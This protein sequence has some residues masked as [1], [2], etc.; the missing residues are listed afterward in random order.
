MAPGERPKPAHPAPRIK[1]DV[2]IVHGKVDEGEVLK[3]VRAKGYWPFR[4]CYEDGLRRAPKLRGSM[5]LRLNLD[6]HGKVHRPKKLTAELADA[7]VVDCVLQA[8]GALSLNL[9]VRGTPEITVEISLY[10]GDEPVGPRQI[11]G[12]P[13]D[14]DLSAVTRT[15]RETWPQLRTCYADG[16]AHDPALWGRLAVRLAIATRGRVAEASE[17]ESRFPDPAVTACVCRVLA[18]LDGLAA[19][20]GTRL[21]YPLRFGVPA[22]DGG[23]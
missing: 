1:V 14:A 3:Q 11:A 9:P 18:Q 21:V 13:R 7:Q 23:N 5:R 20:D 15:L 12:V 8:A 19:P 16:L 2:P 22:S 17:I 4:K 10:P 6:A